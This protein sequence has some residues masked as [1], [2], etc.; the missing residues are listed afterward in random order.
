MLHSATFVKGTQVCCK[1]HLIILLDQS[2][3]CIN[4]VPSFYSGFTLVFNEKCALESAI[5]L[6]LPSLPICQNTS[7]SAKLYLLDC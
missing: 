6:A 4:H 2:Q 3:E 5:F 1:C 7:K